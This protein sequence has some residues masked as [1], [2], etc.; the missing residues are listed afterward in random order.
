MP[1]TDAFNKLFKSM[2]KEYVG[3]DV[4]K[5]YRKKYGKMY[6]KKD[7]LQFA[8]ATA[9]SKGIPVDKKPKKKGGFFK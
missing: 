8:I 4:P 5:E 1:Y 6:N 7:V 9:K 2:K 3:E